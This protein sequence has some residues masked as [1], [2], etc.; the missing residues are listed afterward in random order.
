MG[1]A[2]NEIALGLFTGLALVGVALGMTMQGPR[3][4]VVLVPSAALALLGIYLL[5]EVS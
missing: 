4:W 1:E 5:A 3:K 2:L